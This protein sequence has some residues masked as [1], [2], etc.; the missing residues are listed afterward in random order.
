MVGLG[1]GV[2]LG[3]RRSRGERDVGA[4]RVPIIAL[5]A[6]AYTKDFQTCA[7]AGMDEVVTKGRGA[8]T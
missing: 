8:D 1:K 6:N 2:L 5:T 4:A 3:A 7:N